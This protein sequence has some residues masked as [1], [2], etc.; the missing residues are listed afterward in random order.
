MLSTLMYCPITF[1]RPIY[2]TMQFNLFRQ[3][4]IRIFARHKFS[5]FFHLK[6]PISLPAVSTPHQKFVQRPDSLQGT[7]YCY[8]YLKVSM[9]LQAAPTTLF[10]D[11]HGHT[12]IFFQ[13]SFTQTLIT[14]KNYK[15]T[16][17]EKLWGVE[18]GSVLLWEIT[19]TYSPVLE[20][21]YMSSCLISL[22][23]TKRQTNTYFNLPYLDPLTFYCFNFFFFFRVEAF[24]V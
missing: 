20:W 14:H 7:H 1:K 10:K 17:L 2:G 21:P 19:N 22:R 11:E 13:N 23:V 9:C 3:R 4:T 6:Q 12:L 18:G 5:L 8:F 24:T 15:I 16:K